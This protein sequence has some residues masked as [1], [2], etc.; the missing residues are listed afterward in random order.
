MRNAQ[1]PYYLGLRL[2]K[3]NVEG[4][5]AMELAEEI[6]IA[7]RNVNAYLTLWRNE[8]EVYICGWRRPESKSGDWVPVYGIKPAPNTK[9]IK[10]PKPMTEKEKQAAYRERHRAMINAKRRN[11]YNLSVGKPITPFSHL[12]AY[13]GV[14]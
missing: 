3:A 8:N 14:L 2:L 5:T 10:K 1:P 13:T 11:R 4:L 12:T 9:D 7:K 6:G